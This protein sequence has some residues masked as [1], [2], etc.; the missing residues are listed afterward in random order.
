MNSPHHVAPPNQT[1]HLRGPSHVRIT[2]IEYGDVEC[3]NCKQADG[4]V[5]ALL[6]MH[7]DRVCPIFRQFP[8]EGV[9]PHAVMAAQAAEAAGS[10]GRF[11]EINE[12]LLTH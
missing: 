4:P 11:W 12:L 10:Q 2:L 7:A 1:G 8:L 5:K 6:R 3:P 9:H